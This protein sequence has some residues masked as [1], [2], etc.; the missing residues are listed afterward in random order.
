[1]ITKYLPISKHNFI[2]LLYIQIY[3]MVMKV[4]FKETTKEK[5]GNSKNENVKMNVWLHKKSQDTK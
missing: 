2:V 5:G 1:M 3:S 4:C